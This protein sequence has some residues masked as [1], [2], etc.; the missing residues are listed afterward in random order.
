MN[1][2]FEI[3]STLLYWDDKDANQIVEALLKHPKV[4]KESDEFNTYLYIGNPEL[5]DLEELLNLI[6]KEAYNDL[7]GWSPTSL[8]IDSEDSTITLYDYYRE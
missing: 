6:P 7:C 4:W 5:S 1:R 8:I 3:K 2:V